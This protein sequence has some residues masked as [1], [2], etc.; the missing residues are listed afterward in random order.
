MSEKIHGWGWV[1]AD[2]RGVARAAQVRGRGEQVDAVRGLAVQV[3]EAGIAPNV[4]VARERQPE[5]ESVSVCWQ[6]SEPG[7]ESARQVA[8]AQ[9]AAGTGKDSASTRARCART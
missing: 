5:P 4:L 2:E 6:K 1:R 9:P 8:R 7:D 3:A